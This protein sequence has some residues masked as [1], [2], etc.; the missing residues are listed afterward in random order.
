VDYDG[1]VNG[2]PVAMGDMDERRPG[3]QR[4]KHAR[5]RGWDLTVNGPGKVYAVEKGEPVAIQV[6]DGF[7]TAEMRATVRAMGEQGRYALQVSL[8]VPV[9]AADTRSVRF[10]CR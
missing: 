10:A 8:L 6:G 5:G 2:Y 4:W 3:A 7:R 1:S 9:T